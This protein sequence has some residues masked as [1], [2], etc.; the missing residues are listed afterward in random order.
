MKNTEYLQ[1][2]SEF[3]NM[4][5]G[6]LIINDIGNV[7]ADTI[8]SELFK[9]EA[10][11]YDLIYLEY[12]FINGAASISKID[13]QPIDIKITYEIALDN[14]KGCHPDGNIK[15]IRTA[16]PELYVLAFASGHESRYKLDKQFKDDDFIRLY[17]KWI[18]NSIY[19]SFAD[20][21]YGYYDNDSLIGFISLKIKNDIGIIGLFAVDEDYRG[22]GIGRKLMQSAIDYCAM[23]GA[24]H[25]EVATQLNNSGACRFY[26]R[27][28]FKRSK[29]F[30]IHHIWLNNNRKN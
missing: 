14:I 3:F 20:V 8:N 7:N 15:E 19:A 23:R 6:R 18:D 5:I 11:S 21:V 27:I 12:P 9:A 22:Q 13:R 24:T 29:A 17:T 16:I 30:A 2:D 25:V 10:E 4:K 26:E 28:G 1:W